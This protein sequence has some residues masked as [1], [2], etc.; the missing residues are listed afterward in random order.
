MTAEPRYPIQNVTNTFEKAL[1][2]KYANIILQHREDDPQQ[3]AVLCVPS[4]Q[5]ENALRRL[6]NDGYEAQVEPSQ[7]IPMTEGQEITL[8]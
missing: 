5:L 6:G 2:I 8:R 7:D 3:V 4:K 1:Q